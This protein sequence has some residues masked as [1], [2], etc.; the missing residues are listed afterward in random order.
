MVQWESPE[1]LQARNRLRYRRDA[2]EWPPLLSRPCHRI[3][4]LQIRAGLPLNRNSPM[5][6]SQAD[7]H[8]PEVAMTRK[9]RPLSHSSDATVSSQVLAALQAEVLPSLRND[10]GIGAAPAT[11]NSVLRNSRRMQHGQHDGCPMSY[12]PMSARMCLLHTRARGQ[13][14]FAVVDQEAS[15]E[16]ISTAQGHL[17]PDLAKIGKRPEQDRFWNLSNS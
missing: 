5:R 15:L 12:A 8:C 9:G 14:W 16:P 17:G 1:R 10:W 2:A 13:L 6:K 11:P 7:R 3:A 4:H